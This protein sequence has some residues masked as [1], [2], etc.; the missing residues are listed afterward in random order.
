FAKKCISARFVQL[1]IK[2]IFPNVEYLFERPTVEL[3][4]LNGQRY[5]LPLGR[6]GIYFLEHKQG[7]EQG[8]KARQAVGHQIFQALDGHRRRNVLA[9]KLEQFAAKLVFGLMT[10]VFVRDIDISQHVGTVEHLPGDFH[11][12]KFN[13][14]DVGSIMQ[15]RD[16]EIYRY[17]VAKPDPLANRR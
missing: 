17:R 4:M 14:K 13:R 16:R 8:R 1:L 2:I 15:F 9:S 12:I 7:T 10:Q 3:E 5:Y 6:W 11:T